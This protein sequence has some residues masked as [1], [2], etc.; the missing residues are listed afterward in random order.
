MLF[1]LPKIFDF[2]IDS[3][4]FYKPLI[5]CIITVMSEESLVQMGVI[6]PFV[7]KIRSMHQ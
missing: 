1:D 6:F 2:M 4:V 3:K 7:V 5:G